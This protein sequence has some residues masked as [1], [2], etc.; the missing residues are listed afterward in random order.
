MAA[1]TPSVTTSAKGQLFTQVVAAGATVPLHQRGNNCYVIS[2]TGA[3]NMRARGPG[4]I[5]QYNSYTTGTGFE[6]TEF[7]LVEV[8]NQNNF[9]VTCSIWVGDASFIDK[10]NIPIGQ[11]FANAVNPVYTDPTHT[12]AAFAA[13]PDISGTVFTD[14]N[15]KKWQAITRISILISNLDAGAVIL[16]QKLGNSTYN[17]G[18]IFAVQPATEIALPVQGGYTLVPPSGTLNALVSEIYLAIPA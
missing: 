18:A 15:G 16:V 1:N 13:V 10:R 8:Q 11:S 5:N 7:H 12:P 17:S 3:I 9:D 14:I 6:N 4:G 2:T